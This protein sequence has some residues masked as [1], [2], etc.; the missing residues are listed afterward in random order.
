MTRK[1]LALA[2]SLAIATFGHSAARADDE[3]PKV[4][5]SGYGT[6]AG[7]FTDDGD[8]QFVAD[9]SRS[10]GATNKLDIG[11]DSRLGVQASVDFKGGLSVTAQVVAKRRLTTTTRGSDKDFDINLDWFY[12][13]YQFAPSLNLRIGRMAVP[14][15]LLS[16]SLNVG[17]SANWLR[18]PVHLYTSMPFNV[19]DGV[20]FNYTRSFGEY[21]VSAQVAHGNAKTNIVTYAVTPLEADPQSSVNVI[22]EH[23]SWLARIG[24]V[25]AKVAAP[26]GMVKDTYIS[27]GLQYDNGELVAMSEVAQRDQNKLPALLDNKIQTATYAYVAAG[28]RFGKLL[29]L[30]MLSHNSLKGTQPAGP[31][32]VLHTQQSITAPSVSLRY[33]MATNVALKAQ[34][35]RYKANDTRLFSPVATDDHAVH[36]FSAGMDFLF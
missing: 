2:A 5:V 19:F 31:G 7:V 35:D 34:I 9:V 29:P 25:R 15:Y 10:K 16:D 30:L 24:A 20:E 18:A 14:T 11:Q 33:D 13:Q 17:Y 32:V 12:G 8:R 6:V 3:T 23:G 28:W 22:V 4:K 26:F 1:P 27:A 36:V 21:N